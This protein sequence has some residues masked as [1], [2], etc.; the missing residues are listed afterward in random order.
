[1]GKSEDEIMFPFA[2]SDAFCAVGFTNGRSDS[3]RRSGCGSDWTCS[4]RNINVW[5]NQQVMGL[6]MTDGKQIV[7]NGFLECVL[8]TI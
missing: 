4:S 3:I 7:H 6:L 5:A 1:M 2:P 8:D